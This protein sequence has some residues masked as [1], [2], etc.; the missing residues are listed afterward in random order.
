MILLHSRKIPQL[1]SCISYRHSNDVTNDLRVSGRCNTKH[2]FFESWVCGLTELALLLM[3]FIL[4]LGSVAN[5]GTLCSRQGQT[6][7]RASWKICAHK[8]SVWSCR[9]VSAHL[10]LAKASHVVKSTVRGGERN[11]KMS[12]S[13]DAVRSENWGWCLTCLLYIPVGP[14]LELTLLDQWLDTFWVCGPRLEHDERHVLQENTI[15]T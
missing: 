13:V 2:F 8:A 12:I 3:C 9:V 14:I 11:S 15:N 1:R 7:K 4:F 10:L 5:L 6:Y